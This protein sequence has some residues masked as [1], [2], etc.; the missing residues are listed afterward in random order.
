MKSVRSEIDFYSSILEPEHATIRLYIG[1][2]YL[3]KGTVR[4][5]ISDLPF[6]VICPI[7]NGTLYITFLSDNEEDIVVFLS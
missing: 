6:K 2:T 3:N 7:F 4:V 1:L 5:F